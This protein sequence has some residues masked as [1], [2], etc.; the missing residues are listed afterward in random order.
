M[1]IQY[2]CGDLPFFLASSWEEI[3][4]WNQKGLSGYSYKDY[5]KIKGLEVIKDFEDEI[6]KSRLNLNIPEDGYSQNEVIEI[7]EPTG[8]ILNRNEIDKRNKLE[9]GIS[10]E[11]NRLKAKFNFDK[12]ILNQLKPLI[13]GNFVFPNKGTM[14]V[15]GDINYQIIDEQDDFGITNIETVSINITA[16]IT[17]G[18]LLKYIKHVWDKLELSISNL[19]N[20]N[21]LSLRDIALQIVK[22]K[23]NTNLSFKKIAEKII[24]DNNIDDPEDKINED[25][26]KT[27]Y[28]VTKEKLDTIAKLKVTKK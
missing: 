12:L 11:V 6:I 15:D 7:I 4:D 22:L 1:K 20:N 2:L 18:K 10:G 25:S 17:K 23:D 21:T 8:F 9:I 14:N 28:H 19:P 16:P 24:K 3:E 26:V 27:K 13:I 5:W